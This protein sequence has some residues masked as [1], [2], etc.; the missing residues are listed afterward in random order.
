VKEGVP[1]GDR[2]DGG[3]ELFGGVIAGRLRARSERYPGQQVGDRAPLIKA[4]DAGREMNRWLGPLFEAMIFAFTSIA[5]LNTLAMIARRRRR[6]LGLLRLAGATRRQ[7]R[8][9]ARWEA[10]L[11]VI[12][13]LGLGLA[14]SAAALLPL[15]HA[16]DGSLRPYGPAGSLV[17]ILGGIDAAGTARPGRAD[18]QRAAHP[19]RRIGSGEQPRPG[20]FAARSSWR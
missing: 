15:S 16:L 10:G 14:I 12:T 19:A 8:S 18:P 3:E 11:I 7:V 17:L 4:I 13:G 9:M 5:V 2:A 20:Q 1:G 6:E